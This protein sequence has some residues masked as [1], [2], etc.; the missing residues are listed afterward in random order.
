[1]AQVANDPATVCRR[2]QR[3]WRKSTESIIQACKHLA[4]AK[5]KLDP[6]E[7]DD[8]VDNDLAVSG[9]TGRK[10]VLI[11]QNRLLCSHGNILPNHWTT[12]YALSELTDAQ[13]RAAIRDGKIHTEMQRADA[14]ALRNPP[15]PLTAD[16]VTRVTTTMA[17]VTR[18]EPPVTSVS[19]HVS[20]I[21]DPGTVYET[22]VVVN[23][24]GTVVPIYPGNGHDHHDD[25]YELPDEIEGI[26]SA[27]NA[28]QRRIEALADRNTD[29][30]LRRDVIGTLEALDV[31]TIELLS[32]L[33]TVAGEVA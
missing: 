25:A 33:R 7:F 21:D 29:P 5:A 6:A 8:M 2:L 16:S 22:R 4:E 23:D 30:E 28:L 17:D 19:R 27:L 20:Q 15:T 9:A 26:Y 14:E 32:L 3:A 1:V 31:K 11:G 13:L 18:G 10:L 12:L 24:A